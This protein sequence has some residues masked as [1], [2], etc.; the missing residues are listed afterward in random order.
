MTLDEQL[1]QCSQARRKLRPIEDLTII[2]F[3]PTAQH[4]WRNCYYADNR[5][6]TPHGAEG[7][8]RCLWFDDQGRQC[9]TYV[10]SDEVDYAMKHPKPPAKEWPQTIKVSEEQMDNLIAA[11]KRKG[12]VRKAL[13]SGMTSEEVEAQFGV[14]FY[15]GLP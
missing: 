5:N 8:T 13:E 10:P 6:E 9:T 3:I 15:R 7:L 4:G 2:A 1:E 14:K 11:A 12:E